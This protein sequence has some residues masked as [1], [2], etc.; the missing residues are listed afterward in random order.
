MT[1]RGD[2]MC[3][4]T[5]AVPRG[6]A[7]LIAD[8]FRANVQPTAQILPEELRHDAHITASPQSRSILRHDSPC[9]SERRKVSVGIFARARQPTAT[10]ST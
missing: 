8:K 5:M 6:Y 9:L 4:S 1:L 3:F 7:L 2:V 10:S